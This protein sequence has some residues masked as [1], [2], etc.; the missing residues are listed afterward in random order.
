DW[1]PARLLGLSLALAGD[2][3]PTFQAWVKG[4][5][6]KPEE[7]DVY[8]KDL[9]TAALKHTK[10]MT[11]LAVQDLAFRS[12]VVWVIVLAIMTLTAVVQ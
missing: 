8:F 6:Y 9:G 5:C 12:L 11:E 10:P 1:I 2:F 7:Q 3:M 4:F